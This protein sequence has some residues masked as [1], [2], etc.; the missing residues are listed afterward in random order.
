MIPK[1]SSSSKQPRS[2]AG[3]LIKPVILDRLR[4]VFTH[5]GEHHACDRLIQEGT[6]ADIF[7]T[8]CL[9]EAVAVLAGELGAVRR[10]KLLLAEPAAKWRPL[11]LIA[12]EEIVGSARF[13]APIALDGD[14]LLTLIAGVTRAEGVMLGVESMLAVLKQLLVPLFRVEYAAHATAKFVCGNPSPLLTFVTALES[15]AWRDALLPVPIEQTG[16]ITRNTTWLPRS[17]EFD[18]QNLSPDPITADWPWQWPCL[19]IMKVEMSQ[20]D[21]WGATYVIEFL[22]DPGAC[23]DM[24]IT[25]YGH[26]FGQD[27][28]HLGRVV[29]PSRDGSFDIVVPNRWTDTEIDVFVPPQATSGPLSLHIGTQH[30]GK[31]RVVNVYRLGDPFTFLGGIPRIL[32]VFLDGRAVDLESVVRRPVRPGQVVTVGWFA[33][34]SP[35]VEVTIE[36]KGTY[37]T[38]SNTSRLPGGFAAS[39][40]MFPNIDE[41]TEVSLALSI[42][43]FCGIGTTLSLPFWVGVPATLNIDFVEITQGVQADKFGLPP[44]VP[45]HDQL[46]GQQ[47]PLVAYKDTAVR[48]HL[49]GDRSGWWFDKVENITGSL[50]VD[51]HPPLPPTT[52]F[53][54]VLG[55]SLPVL[56]TGTVNFTIP[57][58]YLHAGTHQLHLRVTATDDPDGRIDLTHSQSC[59]WWSNTPIPVRCVWL[60]PTRIEDLP[61]QDMLQYASRVLDYLPTPLTD[62]DIASH[63]AF[64]HGYDLRTQDGFEHL[65]NDL[66][67][68]F[69]DDEE[70]WRIRWLAIVP[71]RATLGFVMGISHTPGHV[72]IASQTDPIYGAHELGHTLGLHHVNITNGLVPNGPYDAVDNGGWLRRP[73]FDVR[74]GTAVSL[75]AGD[76]MSYFSPARLGVTTWV[77]LFINR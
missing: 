42:A 39:P 7:L 72:A 17:P 15:P 10:I 25:L 14:A 55:L 69:R 62:I 21:R 24:L 57:A 56:T 65:L 19:G 71:A 12:L 51:N 47:V 52:P 59:H 3:R 44:G 45:E 27:P 8:R 37:N 13:E 2:T 38:F 77:R 20:L 73:P 6:Q 41:P 63:F 33:S 5:V 34:V 54:T 48:V 11:H 50:V 18:P 23:A 58:A 60:E 4:Q 30:N 36:V 31:C 9:D 35:T 68:A 74:T 22:S 43:S 67:D 40:V 26:R 16:E 61:R 64:G 46:I 1:H 29:F 28:D 32:E 76:L 66:E 70:D 53:I 49:R 75:P